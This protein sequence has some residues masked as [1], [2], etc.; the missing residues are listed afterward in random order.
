[1]LDYLGAL[2]AA[3]SLDAVRSGSATITT[4]SAGASVEYVQALSGAIVDGKF[5]PAT[6]KSVKEFQTAH[7]L[8]S[9]G[10][11]DRATMAALDVLAG[12]GTKGVTKIDMTTPFAQVSAAQPQAP[13]VAAT[14]MRAAP[15]AE[16]NPLRQYAAYGL[17]ALA[18]VGLGVA[19][20][21]R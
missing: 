13:S 5:G 9:T 4:G 12:G 15:E 20:F 16:S 2:A 10:V 8:A 11:V 21:K 19:V 18:A 3:P 1:M 17:A 14:Q 7:G 6:E